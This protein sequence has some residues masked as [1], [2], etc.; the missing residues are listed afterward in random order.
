MTNGIF[1]SGEI[2]CLD[3]DRVET[4]RSSLDIQIV[5]A[6]N[7]TL[8]SLVVDGTRVDFRLQM[9]SGTNLDIWDSFFGNLSS[10]SIEIF[11]VARVEIVH[12]EFHNV[13][14]GAIVVN[15]GVKDL[16]VEDSLMETDILVNYY[17]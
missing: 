8:E 4:T 10:S 14:A 7:V 2:L 12:S 15:G 16:T 3:C 11:N 9:R 1:I 6:D 5:D 17:Y 13:T